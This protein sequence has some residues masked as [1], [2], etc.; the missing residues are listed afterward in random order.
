MNLGSVRWPWTRR[1]KKT[2]KF[3][4]S[5]GWTQ[6]RKYKLSIT[7][8]SEV[9]HTA[10]QTKWATTVDHRMARRYWPELS[11]ELSNLISMTEQEHNRKRRLES[12]IY[13][14]E[15]YKQVFG[16]TGERVEQL[17]VIK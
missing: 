17:C 1:P 2:D 4:L 10:G 9:A 5:K 15:Q 12:Q 3:Y 14:K 11:L 13:N 7:P 6:L 8:L 16:Q